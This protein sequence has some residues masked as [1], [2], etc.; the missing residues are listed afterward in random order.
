MM[1]HKENVERG[2]ALLNNHLPGWHEDV[3]L[4]TLDQRTTLV[5]VLAQVF[6]SYDEGRRAL[7]VS[8]RNASDYGFLIVLDAADIKE[9]EH[10]TNEWKA[11]ITAIRNAETKPSKDKDDVIAE[12]AF[13]L[14]R[15]Y[16][17]RTAGDYTFIGV[18]A[19]FSREFMEAN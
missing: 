7:G 9:W 6:G 10:L 1:N 14:Q 11:Q 13:E 3:D 17:E 15:I 16:E 19:E 2:I 18:L 8:N 4:E 12:Y 5:C